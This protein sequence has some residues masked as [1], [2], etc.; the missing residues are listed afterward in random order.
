M[1]EPGTVVLAVSQSG[2]DFPTLAALYQLRQH[3]GEAGHGR[4]FVLTGEAD[5]LMGQAV[6]QSFAK[7]ALWLGRILTNCGGY[8]PSEAA[9]ASVNATHAALCELLFVTCE[10]AQELA[11]A[12]PRADAGRGRPRCAARA[13]RRL[14]RPPRRRDPERRRARPAGPSRSRGR[15]VRRAG[16]SAATC[17]RGISPSCSRGWCW[18]PT[19][20]SGLRVKPSWFAELLPR[21]G[22]RA[23][24]AGCA[25][26]TGRPGRRAL[27]PVPDAAVRLAAALRA[28]AAAAA[29]PGRARAAD[30]RHRATCARSSGC[31]RA[32][33]SASATASP[34]LKPYAADNQDDLIMTHEPVR[35]TLALFGVPDGRRAHLRGH[36]AAAWM[37]AT[38]FASSRSVGGAGA[39]VIT[40]GH[41]PT[42]PVGFAHL[43]AAERRGRRA[44]AAPWI[45]LVEGMY[46]SWERMLAMQALMARVA[47]VVARL[48]PAGVR[49][50]A[51]EGPGLRADHGLAGLRQLSGQGRAGQG[52]APLHA[53]EHAVR[54]RGAANAGQRHR[55]D[56]SAGA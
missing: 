11:A 28:A 40:V 13:R 18:R 23:A 37:T 43:R 5:T 47:E 2:Q 3:F 53:R 14:R 20:A 32:S 39:E 12:P 19:S 8:R 42:S 27:L 24:A 30:R 25:T 9:T 36:E 51:H 16:A 34:S 44:A 35:G 29:P 17:W 26:G 52:A 46:D 54:D 4:L 38:Q 48:L 55:G 6:G 50:V 7:R 21:R 56:H 15:S 45:S 1:I 22:A 41:E 49:P 33:C 31:S 10:T